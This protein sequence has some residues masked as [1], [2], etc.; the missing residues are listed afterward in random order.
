MTLVLR[1]PDAAKQ[2]KVFRL[3]QKRYHQSMTEIRHWIFIRGL[4]RHSGHWGPFVAEFR[5]KFPQDQIELL[6]LRGNGTL[7][8]S[9]S[10]LSI[11]DN[12]RDLKS[13]S[14]LAKKGKPLHLMTISLGSMIGVEWSRLFPDEV[15]A[16]IA[17][18]TSDKG[19][20]RFFERMRPQNYGGLLKIA[21]HPENSALVEEPFWNSSD[22]FNSNRSDTE[23]LKMSTTRTNFLRQLMAAGSYRFPKVKPKPQ[24]LM[25]CSEQDPLVNSI[26]TYKIAD[27]WNLNVRSHPKAGHDLPLDDGPWVCEEIQTWLKSHP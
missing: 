15:A 19:T 24:I 4:A 12:V 5:N 9:P 22:H 20:S 3:I 13:R 2:N 6:D 18:N 27:M 7:A 8:H 25:L 17:M 10:F 14:V 16:L 1:A 23:R 21:T 11:A 26:C